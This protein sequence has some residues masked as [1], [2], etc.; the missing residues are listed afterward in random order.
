MKTRAWIFI[1]LLAANLAFASETD[2]EIL[3]DLDFFA[4]F[5]VVHEGAIFD[6]VP[7]DDASA[8]EAPAAAPSS[9]AGGSS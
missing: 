3:K 7:L 6:E 5:E 9:P 8:V 2:A 1:A 4:E